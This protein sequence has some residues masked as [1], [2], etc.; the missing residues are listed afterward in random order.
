MTLTIF[1]LNPGEGGGY[2]FNR[3]G[4]SNQK[5]EVRKRDTPHVRCCKRFGNDA[6]PLDALHCHVQYD[7]EL[8]M[9]PETRCAMC[10]LER[11]WVLADGGLPP[12][13]VEERPFL[14]ALKKEYS[15]F[16]WEVGAK[17]MPTLP[18]G[19]L[20]LPEIAKVCFE[21]HSVTGATL[22]VMFDKW[23]KQVNVR[24]LRM[25]EK[26]PLLCEQLWRPHGLRHGAVYNMKRRLVPASVGAPFLC[27]SQHI[28]ETVYGIE[29]MAGVAQEILPD[30]L[31]HA[32]AR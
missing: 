5:L 12:P 23:V 4:K 22:N 1:N 26:A 21:K 20:D 16:S 14:P 8:G 19:S 27:M 17:R 31:G 28:W 3:L 6:N 29:E 24:R 2:E 15:K 9:L 10:A 13:G 30:L 11:L 25:D 18:D 7:P 32:R